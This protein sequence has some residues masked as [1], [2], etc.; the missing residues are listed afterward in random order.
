MDRLPPQM[1]YQDS[2]NL[3]RD[4]IQIVKE[5]QAL[6]PLPPYT[7]YFTSDV[8]TRYTH[9]ETKVDIST[10]KEWL[11]TPEDLPKDFLAELIMDVLAIIMDQ[12]VFQI[13]EMFWQQDTGTAI[14][15]PFTCSYANLS[16]ALREM[17]K[18]LPIFSE[19][20]IAKIIHL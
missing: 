13:N 11:H 15:T 3:P 10:I 12:N 18:V 9:I 16:Y 4:S 2:I 1:S 8:N 7:K 5:L 19:P 14:G 17:R 6:R 20:P